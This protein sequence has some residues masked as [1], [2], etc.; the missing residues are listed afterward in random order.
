MK[1]IFLLSILLFQ[2]TL[3]F[4][5]NTQWSPWTNM[6]CYQGFKTSASNN[7]LVKSINEYSWIMKIKNNYNRRVHFNMSWIVGNEKQ[8]IG[9]FSLNPG[10]E[11]R[12]TSFYFKS[13][14]TSWQV[15][16]TEVCFGENWMSCTNSCYAECDNGSPKQPNCDKNIGS[17]NSTNQTNTSNKQNTQQND[18]SE[19]NRS[20]ADLERQLEEKN[21]EITRQNEENARLGQIWN[22]AIKAGVDAHNSGNYT[23]AKNQFTIAIN[24]SSNE[25]NRQNAKNYFNKSVE[26]EKSQAKIKAIGEFTTA[27]TNLITYFANR[28]NASRNSLT[29]EDGQALMD[30][31]NSDNP[32]EYVQN[33]IQIF[34]DLGYTHRETEIKDKYVV[35]TM[36]NDVRNINDFMLIFIRPANYDNYNRISFRYDRKQKLKEQLAILGDNLKYSDNIEISG[37]SPLK[38]KIEENKKAEEDQKKV[39]EENKKLKIKQ[40]IANITPVKSKNLID[41]TIS[42]QSIIDKCIVAMGGENKLKAVENLIEYREEEDLSSITIRAFG[43]FSYVSNYKGKSSK[44]VFDGSSG[45]TDFSSGRRTLYEKEISFYK[46]SQPLYILELKLRQDLTVGEIETIKGKDYI[47]IIEP[48][49]VINGLTYS[50]KIYFDIHNGLFF[51]FAT[52]ESIYKTTEYEFYSDYKEVKGIKFPF[53]EIRTFKDYPIRKTI[54]T[55][56]KINQNI[57]ENDFK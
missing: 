12:H 38:Q 44:I 53:T 25:T 9:R 2:L 19:Y 40:E 39:E 51:G 4:G 10:E 46:K 26:A 6:S 50:K 48:P 35:I 45:Y 18:L 24:N 1:K 5:Q 23:E 17:T 32:T 57:S 29:H 22:N 42:V 49:E 52:T 56:I 15:E 20:K 34:T 28:K 3:V 55:D 30:I 21:A 47:T 41:S 14:S 54:T 37:I 8:S 16:V 13:N 43:K 31:V 11:T 33:I 36:N 7:G 27:T